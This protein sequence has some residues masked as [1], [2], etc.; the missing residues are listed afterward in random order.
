MRI[1][2]ESFI[3]AIRYEPIIFKIIPLDISRYITYSKFDINQ[4]YLIF[5][6]LS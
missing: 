3:N 6:K 1:E 2:T 4:S 5:I